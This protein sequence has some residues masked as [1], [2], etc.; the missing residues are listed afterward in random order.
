M[1]YNA[2]DV[3]VELS[4]IIL[5]YHKDI[6]SIAHVTA[7]SFLLFF[8]SKRCKNRKKRK[9]AKNEQCFLKHNRFIFPV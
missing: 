3:L 5:L 6:Q 7:G 8:K 4:R 1:F 9:A 2:V